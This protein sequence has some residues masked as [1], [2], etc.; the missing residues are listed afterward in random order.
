MYMASID[1]YIAWSV[2]GYVS[3]VME[4][5]ESSCTVK[6]WVELTDISWYTFVFSTCN[7]LFWFLF[8]LLCGPRYGTSLESLQLGWKKRYGGIVNL[9]VLRFG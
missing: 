4:E 9:M 6:P 1:G 2:F 5:Q 3:V 8:G 7:V